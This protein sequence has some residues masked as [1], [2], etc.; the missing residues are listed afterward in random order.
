MRKIKRKI[1][2]IDQQIQIN[3]QQVTSIYNKLQ[4]DINA[5]LHAPKTL[6][7][8]FLI[9][10]LTTYRGQFNKHV[11]N[12]T[13]RYLFHAYPTMEGSVVGK[14]WQFLPWAL[15]SLLW[16]KKNNFTPLKFKLGSKK[17]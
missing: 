1:R 6:G 13:K 9:G 17:K 16:L 14:L 5:W 11:A 10:F 4:Q 2:Q 15:T 12:F 3:K 7:G 8:A